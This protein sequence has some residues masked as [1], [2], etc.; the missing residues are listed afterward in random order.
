MPNMN[1]E[2]GPKHRNPSPNWEPIDFVSKNKNLNK[3][4]RKHKNGKT[5]AVD[6]VFN[7]KQKAQNQS[8][9]KLTVQKVQ[10]EQKNS[11]ESDSSYAKSNL[12]A[13][14]VK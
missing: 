5:I 7:I 13:S 10:L 11:I 9:F 14:S 3:I 2:K 12:K 6:D 1:P 8:N 4:Q